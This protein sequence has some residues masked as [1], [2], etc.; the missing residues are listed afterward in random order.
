M[1]LHRS[2]FA[3]ATMRQGFTLVELLVVMAVISILVA[4][5]LPAV[6]QSRAA[7]RA[8][9]CRNQLRQIALAC[10]NFESTYGHFPAG[11]EGLKTNPKRLE[12]TWLQSLLPYLE[13][14]D[15][16]ALSE[17]AYEANP[18]P[19]FAYPH[20]PL[21]MAV[22]AFSCPEDGRVESPQI[23]TTLA[24]PVGLTSYIGISGM[25]YRD[26][27]GILGFNYRVRIAEITDGTSNTLMCGERPPSPDFNL[28]WWYT[29]A[30][31]DGS[32]SVD[33]FM[34]MRERVALYGG[35]RIF[36]QYQCSDNDGA[37]QPGKIDRSCD[38]MHFWS[39]HSGG[40]HFALADGSVRFF[41]YE[42]REVMENMAMRN[43][44]IVV[45]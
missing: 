26:S 18:I 45:P 28:G 13:R 3:I 41:S 7:A 31:Q 34:G 40:A 32:G 36:L 16:Y 43:D 17:S 19:Y 4:L 39:L 35:N 1:R 24:E 15:L 23:S 37:Y 10:H 9:M 25:D 2:E 5:L 11:K 33:M 30:G 22:P 20:T 14:A 21:S 38:S 12:R 27:R 6:Q 44:G 8:T 42:S 29:G